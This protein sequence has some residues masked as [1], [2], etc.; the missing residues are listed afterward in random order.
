MDADTET[1]VVIEA[2]APTPSAWDPPADI[3]ISHVDLSRVEEWLQ[4]PKSIIDEIGRVF[5][6]SFGTD[7][8]M[9]WRLQLPR[10]PSANLPQ[11][12]SAQTQA[13]LA[14]ILVN[15]WSMRTY[16]IDCVI[17]MYLAEPVPTKTGVAETINTLLTVKSSDGLAMYFAKKLQMLTATDAWKPEFAMSNAQGKIVKFASNFERYAAAQYQ[18]GNSKMRGVR[19]SE[20][21]TV[22]GV[23]DA[24]N[25]T[26]ASQISEWL[27]KR[28]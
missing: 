5:V 20:R 28:V 10:P 11:S 7:R 12:L 19:A 8:L 4:Y 15:L 26:W 3:A 24:Y 1:V 6:E 22:Q 27:G 18:C 2:T 25:Q 17:Q 21:T 14:D 13:F 23:V 9:R 16:Y